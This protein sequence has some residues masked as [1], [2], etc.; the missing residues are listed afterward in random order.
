ML[1]FIPK[2]LSLLCEL[3]LS[4]LLMLTPVMFF[5]DIVSDLSDILFRR[6]KLGEEC[7]LY[8]YF[9]V[10]RFYY[11]RTAVISGLG[12]SPTSRCIFVRVRR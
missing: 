2:Y 1:F 5:V 3:L 7:L 9:G 4:V 12:V 10:S 11:D 8:F 6:F